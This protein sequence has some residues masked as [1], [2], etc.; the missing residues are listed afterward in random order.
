MSFLRVASLL[1]AIV[2]AVSL[3]LVSPGVA[4]P[5]GPADFTFPQSKDAPG[6]VTF[7]HAEH[8]A[9]AEKCSAC[10][11]KVFKMKKGQN[12]TFTMARMKSGELC[13]ACHNG[14]TEMGGKAVFGVD[15]KANCEK[16]HKK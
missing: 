3:G 11:T 14:K 12:G 1:F 5:K 7:S 10:H 6:H 13:G 8:M 9:K 4:Q 15:D 16:C 2:F